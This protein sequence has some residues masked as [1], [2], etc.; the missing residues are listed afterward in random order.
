MSAT[1]PDKSAMRAD[2]PAGPG[3]R[4]PQPNTLPRPQLAFLSYIS[5]S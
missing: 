4:I 5:M 3:R 1:W 2:F